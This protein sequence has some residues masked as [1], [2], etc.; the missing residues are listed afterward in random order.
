MRKEL[1]PYEEVFFVHYQC[2]DFD[3]G[4]HITTLCIYSC[5]RAKEYSGNEVESIKA[6]ADKVKELQNKGLILIH[7]NQDRPNFGTDHINK[8][9]KDLTGKELNLEYL[10]DLN[11]ASW[12]TVKYGDKYISHPR[13]D[14]L[15]ELNDFSGI[16]E[17]EHGQRTFPT[18]R[19]LLLAK[20]YLNDLQGTL[21]TEVE[22]RNYKAKHY[23]LAYL[24]EC[25]AKGE[26]FPIGNKKELERIGN[27]RMGAGKG[28]RFY[29]VFNEIINKDLN[30]ENNLI[31]IGGKD[32]R[33]AV[34]ELS[35]TPELVETYLQNKQL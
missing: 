29:K 31:E 4:E 35:R 30:A 17:K 24:F 5:G 14:K 8:R 34:L 21:K 22:T 13:L 26:S 6:Y 25:N 18:N 33:K 32:W 15:A 9:Y 28:N 27:E 3:K 11:L 19:L 7:W 10:N 23:V 12:L 1:P 16:R 2:A 20:I